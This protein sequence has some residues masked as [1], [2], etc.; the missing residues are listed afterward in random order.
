LGYLS[1]LP[2]ALLHLPPNHRRSNF[3]EKRKHKR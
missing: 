3:V 2:P 1:P